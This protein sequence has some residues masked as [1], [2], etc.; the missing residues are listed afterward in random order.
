MSTLSIPKNL[1]SPEEDSKNLRKAVEGWGT[2]EDALIEILCHRNAAQRVEIAKTYRKLYNESLVSRLESELSGDFGKAMI[3]WTLDPAIRDAKYANEALK[4]FN[5]KGTDKNLLPLVEVACASSPDHL[6]E[7]RKAYCS[8]FSISLEEDIDHHLVQHHSFFE[9]SVQPHS[10]KQLLMR[11]VSS[12]KYDGEDVDIEIAKA[13]ATML[14]EVIRKKQPHHEEVIR[15]LGTRSKC[16]LKATFELYKQIRGKT[17]VEDIDKY[18]GSDALFITILKVAVHCIESPEKHF[19]EVVRKSIVGLG[20]DEDSLT[21]AIVMR[22]EIDMK[23]IREEYKNYK[24]SIN[25]DIIGDT[26]GYYKN[27]LISLVG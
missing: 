19:A 11:F 3:L 2:D 27:F 22:A 13:E 14:N 6:I 16:H 21:R 10:L 12:Y 5:K 7:V 23:M 26:S 24:T 20:T 25:D 1:P 4:A 18:K 15:I 8:L 9:R 17:I